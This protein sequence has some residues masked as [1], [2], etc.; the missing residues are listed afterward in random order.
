MSRGYRV[1][2]DPLTVARTN[3]SASDELCIEVSLLPVL[4]EE[5]MRDLV[6]EALASEGWAACNDGGLEKTVAPGLVATLSADGKTVTVSMT[7]EREVTGAAV[8]ATQAEQL[9][10]QNAERAKDSI[11]RAA[12]TALAKAEGDVRAALDA[13]IQRVYVK[14]LEEKA[15]SMGQLESMEQT[16]GADGTV[17]IVL[18]IRT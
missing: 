12:T 18:K 8:N 17:E 6:R 16:V 7:Q 3:V 14:A 5:R 1:I 2:M 11:R 9:A 10:Q 15:R 13:T 4:G